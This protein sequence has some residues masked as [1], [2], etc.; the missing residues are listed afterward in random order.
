M[1]IKA[2]HFLS[3]FLL[4]VSMVS[5]SAQTST[6]PP[7]LSAVGFQFHCPGSQTPIVQQMNIVTDP[8]ETTLTAV[9]IQISSGYVPS[10]DLLTLTGNYPQFNSFWNA[11]T[12]KL[13]ITSIGVPAQSTLFA[14][15]I[16]SVVYTNSNVNANGT[17]TF[18]ITVGQANYL[19]STG[20]YYQ[21][22][23]SLNI[24]WVAAKAAAEQ[25]TYYGLQGY[26]ATLTAPDE[27]QLSGEQS[28]GA[29]WIGGSD[30]QQ[31]GV[32]KWMTGPEA[33]TVFWNGVANGSSPNFAFW[34]NSEPNNL[35]GEHYAHITAPGVGI[36]G[37]WNDLTN[38]GET[39]GDYQPKG[40]IVEFGGMPGD[41]VLQISTS[42][43]L[44]F[45][46]ITN[47]SS[48]SRCGPGSLVLS[49]TASNGN[50]VWYANPSGGTALATGP[51]FTTPVLT[52]T[53]TYYVTAS[54]ASCTGRIAV[55]ATIFDIPQLTI[56]TPAPSCEG[57]VILSGSTTSGT[58]QWYD[59]ET[60]TQPVASGDS[61]ET[62]I[63]TQSTTYY[64][65][66]S[67]ENCAQGSVR[68]PVEITIYPKPI[69]SDSQ[70]VICQD[71]DLSLDAGLDNVTYFWPHSGETTRSVTVSAPGNYEVTV[72]TLAPAFCSASKTFTVI[73]RNPPDVIGSLV[74]GNSLTI[75]TSNSGDFE[76]SIDGVNFQSS[77]IFS[78]DGS[79]I[80][81]IYA[82]ETNGCGNDDKPFEIKLEIPAFFTPNQ[83]GF[84]D[85]W[86]V[87]GFVFFPTAKVALF[88]RYGKL[89][90]QLNVQSHSWDGTM[91]D[92]ELPSTDYWFVLSIEGISDIRGHFSLKR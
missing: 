32:W 36:P 69:L 19:P 91:N 41:P 50:P 18:S 21:F 74:I 47:T 44:S 78:V 29:G 20:H 75:L 88:D 67:S 8:S 73:Q 46:S 55:T 17:R 15:V 23:P 39:S 43:S 33:G 5:L 42:T 87:R 76:Y 14:D 45:E 77:P 62:P 60:A 84:Q 22:I 70:N 79:P 1:R 11:S 65:Q 90:K 40:Y 12:G 3:Y 34:N 83:D 81:R 37:S 49:A 92:R 71:G 86:S 53:T 7:V 38:T 35:N 82:L 72:T 51:D 27:S 85:L 66:V 10:Q 31:E 64:A 57:T 24:S 52:Q 28:S 2:R 13:T 48:A 6:I 68:I 25:S 58:I 56:T 16:E 61:F 89:L 80:D 9:Y 54:G 26:L 63:L 30:S 4:L 59:T